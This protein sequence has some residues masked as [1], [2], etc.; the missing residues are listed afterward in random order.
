MK[1]KETLWQLLERL[2]REAGQFSVHIHE[3]NRYFDTATGKTKKLLKKH[4]TDLHKSIDKL[5]SI[6][7]KFAKKKKKG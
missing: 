6:V 5:K 3:A 4:E 2:D 7:K 1:K